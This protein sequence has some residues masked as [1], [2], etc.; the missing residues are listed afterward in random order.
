M[1]RPPAV[2]GRFYP[3]E[4]ERLSAQLDSFLAVQS[5]EQRIL[6]R[7]CLVPHAGYIYS[8]E[9]AA[10]VYLRVEI[11]PRVILIGPRHFPRG[12]ALAILSEDAWQPP[13]ALA[14]PHQALP[15]NIPR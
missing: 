11:P 3:S 1:I 8:G 6:A 5:Q 9:L 7:A 2:A 10:A 13:P 15:T 4:P 14:P 12:S